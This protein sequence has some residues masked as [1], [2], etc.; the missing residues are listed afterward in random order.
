MTTAFAHHWVGDPA[1]LVSCWQ[2]AAALPIILLL[3]PFA[4]EQGRCRRLQYNM[5]AALA[6]HGVQACWLDLP[7]TGDSPVDETEI[8]APMWLAAISAAVDWCSSD[9]RQL[10]LL[11]G[12]RLGGA[13]AINWRLAQ[14]AATTPV[15]AIEPVSGPA[16][17]RTLLRTHMVQDGQTSETLLQKMAAGATIDAAGYP[18]NHNSTT[19]LEQFVLPK[20]L[21]KDVTVIRSALPDLPPWL[22]VEPSATEALAQHLADQLAA[23]Y[24]RVAA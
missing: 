14:H 11:G 18:L 10:V 2:P 22:Q 3:S 21:P 6:A 13:V 5:S 16:A 9:G 20:H 19:A 15:A 24:Q 8:T 4:E 12:L 7:G 17:L 23:S 1:G